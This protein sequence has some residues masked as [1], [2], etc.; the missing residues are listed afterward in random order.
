MTSS[1]RNASRPVPRTPARTSV[2]CLI[3]DVVLVLAFAA[4]GRSAHGEGLAGIP[5]TAW[6]FLV[7]LACGWLATR[8]WRSPL[9]LAPT[10]LLLW[11]S[12]VVIGMVLRQLTGQGTH[13][14][15]VVVTLVVTAVFLLGYRAIAAGVRRRKKA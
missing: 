2:L 11:L 9:A 4:F 6:P 8:A 12:T 13:W 10:G 3:A 7:G 5:L 14:S 15:F 1:Q